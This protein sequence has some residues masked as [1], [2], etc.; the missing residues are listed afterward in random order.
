M[1]KKLHQLHKIIPGCE[2]MDNMET[3]FQMTA[4]YIFALQLKASFLQSLCVFYDV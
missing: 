1:R 2:V 4:N 3:L